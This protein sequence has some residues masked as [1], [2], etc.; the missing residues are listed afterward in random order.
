MILVTGA[1]GTIGR[2]LVTLLTSERIPVR[3]VS[4]RPEAARLPDAEVVH[5]DLSDPDTLPALLDGV[6]AVFLLSTGDERAAHDVNLA[7]AVRNS[8]A[9]RIVKIS[10]LTAGH[11]RYTDVVSEWQRRGERA[12]MDSG[13]SWTLLRPGAF[14]SNTLAWAAM[15]RQAGRVFAPFPQHAT[16]PIDPADIAAVAAQVLTGDGHD[17]ATYELTGPA[18][19]TVADQVARL[20]SALGRSIE[21]VRVPVEV[22]AERMVAN[23]TS[24]VVA[25]AVLSTLR[26]AGESGGGPLSADVRRL[27][28]REP[29]GYDDWLA[30]HLDAF[31]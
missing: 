23:G 28:G 31:R 1:T 13:V 21:V 7:T 6:T 17:G 2:Q 5:G 14:M 16:A 29:R 18:R 24:P 26:L 11:P 3:A 10:A 27:L 15:I 30:D 25:N 9:R 8:S 22:A 12:V 20:G 19:L 4:R